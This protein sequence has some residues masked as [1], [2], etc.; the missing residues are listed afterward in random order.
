VRRSSLGPWG[1]ASVL[2]LALLGCGAETEDA[3][4]KPKTP[5]DRARAL[6]AIDAILPPRLDLVALCN[7]VAV[8]SL[9]AEPSARAEVMSV[10]AALRARLWRADQ[11]DADGREA[12]EL[13]GA[14]ARAVTGA[15][16]GCESDRARALLLGEIERNAAVSYRELYLS[17]RRQ[18]ALGEGDDALR[19]CTSALDRDLARVLAFRPSAEAM[20]E[21][22][23][24]GD[25]EAATLRQQAARADPSAAIATAP[26]ATTSA[27]A[28]AP[29]RLD[30][31]VV[32]SPDAARIPEGPVQL[33]S[34]EPYGS[35]KS[36]RV[37]IHLT[38]PA[39]FEV[40]TLGADA[41]AG[42]DRRIYLDIKNAKLKGALREL[43]VGGAVRRVRVGKRDGGARVVLDLSTSLYRRIFYLP[44]P[45]RIVVDVSTRPPIR[46]Q[47][48]QGGARTVR[49][50]ALDPGHGG[51]DGGALGPTGLAEK[52]VALDI[53]HRVAPVLA[54]EL[55]IDTL[56]TRDSDVFVPLD[57]RTAR[58]NAFHADLFIS[59]H[60]NATE[61]GEAHGVQTYVLDEARESDKAAMRLAAAEN[62]I[63]I[64]GKP[65]DIAR[66]DEETATIVAGMGSPG[67]TTESIQFATLLQR[68][69]MA[70][71]SERYPDTLDGGIRRAGFFVLVGADMPAVLFETSFISNSQEESRLSTADYRQKMADSIV[72]AIRAYREGK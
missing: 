28:G 5:L 21:L 29:P 8:A 37:V 55:K 42:K 26:S 71:L 48:T 51:E 35:E 40:G 44:E 7:E 41:D 33:T 34:I 27:Q 4:A 10:A 52:D 14:A 61:D 67:L 17:S 24:E 36:A 69:A 18:R 32:V 19:A 65:V 12:V 62:S 72:N 31:D 15:A 13:Y 46:A 58:A 38:G 2:V 6:L 56:L 3:P 64:K 47:T 66:L 43:E 16:L 63:R 53:A 45:F 22:E 23:R 57:E 49:R 50:V 60:C 25:R 9:D 20:A 11:A 30:E 1:A 70:S 68:S 39:A 59:I 54:H